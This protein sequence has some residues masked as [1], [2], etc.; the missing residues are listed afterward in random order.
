[1]KFF[2][3]CTENRSITKGQSE[4]PCLAHLSLVIDD[5]LCNLCYNEIKRIVNALDVKDLEFSSLSEETSP[6]FSPISSQDILVDVSA[7]ST[8]A[9]PSVCAALQVSP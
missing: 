4:K 3:V 5:N 6:D 9:V 7:T 8:A 1:M 2:Y